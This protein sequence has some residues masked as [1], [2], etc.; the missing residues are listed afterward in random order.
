MR[1]ILIATG[2]ALLLATGLAGCAPTAPTA[3]E[4]K[5][6]ADD[7]RASATAAMKN[8]TAKAKVEKPA[9]PTMTAG[10]KNALGAG[11]SYLSFTAFSR[12][13]LIEQLHSSAGD[14]YS[15][16]DA[17]YAADHAGADWKAEAAEAAKGYLEMTSFSRAGLIEQLHS[18]AGDGYTLAQATYGV[19]EAGL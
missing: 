14:G 10:Q 9:A 1:R 8:P 18:S 2:T 11:K 16:A 17:T 3:A 7:G 13:G 19:D 15:L 5:S 6:A 4:S 12:K